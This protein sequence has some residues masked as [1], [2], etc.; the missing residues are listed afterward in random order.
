MNLLSFAPAQLVFTY[1]T[2]IIGAS[3]DEPA[4]TVCDH[5]TPK[6]DE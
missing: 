1:Y 3:I 6:S 4:H 5:I 2:I